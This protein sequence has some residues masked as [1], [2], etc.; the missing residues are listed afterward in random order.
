MIC[1]VVLIRLHA[2]LGTER[3]ERFLAQ[4][5]EVL[6]PIPGV[7]NLR[8]GR[9]LLPASTHPFAL[10]MEFLDEAALQSYQVHPEHQRFLAEIIGPLVEHKQV[11]DYVAP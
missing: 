6:G 4:A 8:V 7:R 11:L 3:E 9:N 5:R 2:G 10:V 1:H